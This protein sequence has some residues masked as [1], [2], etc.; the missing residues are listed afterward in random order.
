MATSKEIYSESCDTYIDIPDVYRTLAAVGLTLGDSFQGVKTCQVSN[1]QAFAEVEVFDTGSMMPERY[2]SKYI[3]HPSTLDA[4]IQ[5]AW[6]ILGAGRA[7]LH[8]LY[9]ASSIKDVVVS[10]NMECTAGATFQVY[11]SGSESKP[12]QDSVGFTFFATQSQDAVQPMIRIEGYVKAPVQD[13]SS[14]CKPGTSDIDLCYKFIWEPVYTATADHQVNGTTSQPSSFP[15]DYMVGA[16]ASQPSLG[17]VKHQ[18][19]GIATR[20]SSSSANHEVKGIVSRSAPSPPKYHTDGYATP[21]PSKSVDHQGNRSE[22]SSSPKDYQRNE[23]VSQPSLAPANHQVDGIVSRQSSSPAAD[24][25]NGLSSAPSLE[26][27]DHQISRIPSRPS[28]PPTDHQINEIVLSQPLESEGHQVNETAPSSSLESANYE[29]NGIASTPL[30]PSADLQVNQSAS[31]S[32]L[33][34]ADH[35]VDGMVSSMSSQPTNSQSKGI[36]SEPCSP[37]ADHHVYGL[38]S[39][40]TSSRSLIPDISIVTLD[41][42]YALRDIHFMTL[43]NAVGQFAAKRPTLDSIEEVD[44]E[45]KILIVLIELECPCLAAMTSSIFDALQR[46]TTKASGIIWPIRGGF[47]D[48]ASPNL[49]MVSGFVRSVRSESTLTFV[50]IDLDLRPSDPMDTVRIVAEVF[51]RSF[52]D[53]SV[54]ME[55]EYMERRGKLFIPR[56][57]RDLQLSDFIRR[58][59]DGTPVQSHSQSFFQAGRNLTLSIA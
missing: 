27:A 21:S 28:S 56:L 12:F 37:P 45:G 8:N 52:L 29:V 44:P 23:F 30:S 36:L 57:K 25:Y 49:N 17:S 22:P 6:P 26:S 38:Q 59:T 3:I 19:K 1:K 4:I 40:P 41:G 7:G 15:I 16:L 43:I 32:S 39:T 9:L 14:E 5:A 20:S 42:Q 54:N 24:H 35:R 31:S 53:S 51:R 58:N 33:V 18:V 50:T 34:S 11:C 10:R 46:L 2:E 48:S 13:T 47:L 55:Y